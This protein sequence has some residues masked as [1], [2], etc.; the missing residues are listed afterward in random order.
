MLSK[1]EHLKSSGL[2]IH[3]LIYLLTVEHNCF[4]ITRLQKH[5]H[6]LFQSSNDLVLKQM[7]AYVT[8][9]QLWDLSLFI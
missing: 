9:Q 5:H 2:I 1:S 6:Q 8:V 7:R 4:I 3:T